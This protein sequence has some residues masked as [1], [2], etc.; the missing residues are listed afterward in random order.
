M[1]YDEAFT[2]RVRDIILLTHTHVEEKKMFGGTAFLVNDKLCVG[3]RKERIMVRIDPAV[4]DEAVE[5]DGCTPM[6]MRGKTINGYV[7]ID[8]EVL[9]TK[10]ELQYWIRL[11]LDYNRI[12]QPAKKKK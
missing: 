10:K 2:K 7:T 9:N 8:A 12:A 1:A 3:V 11:A 5:K 4:F 6:I